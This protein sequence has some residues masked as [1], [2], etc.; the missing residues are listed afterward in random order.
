MTGL[1]IRAARALLRIT[2]TELASL[3]RVGPATIRRAELENG[4]VAMTAANAHAVRSALEGAGIFFLD[5]VEGL[6]DGGVALRPGAK[7]RAGLDEDGT[8]TGDER[9]G[10]KA[11]DADMAAYWS[12][13]PDQWASLSEIGRHVLSTEMFGDA[14]AADEVFGT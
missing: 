5:P 11:L 13:H 1:Q 9:G 2:S 14:Y 4:E 6:H 8:D 12:Q 3:S 10:L 7:P